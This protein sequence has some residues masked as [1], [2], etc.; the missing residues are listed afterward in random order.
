[1]RLYA[2][3]S[4]FNNLKYHSLTDMCNIRMREGEIQIKKA[5]S[6]DSSLKKT[7]RALDED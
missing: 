2:Y 5:I 7:Y 6:L 1:M 4:A 3:V